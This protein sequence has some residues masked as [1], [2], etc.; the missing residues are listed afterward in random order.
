[1]FV[2]DRTA[3]KSKSKKPD[4]V[5][6]IPEAD[7]T[8]APARTLRKRTS[9]K[10]VKAQVLVPLLDVLIQECSLSLR[11]PDNLV[12]KP[13]PKTRKRA[14][15]TV[16]TAEAK[17]AA[18]KK[19]RVTARSK[20]KAKQTEED[21]V[22]VTAAEEPVAGPST[23]EEQLPIAAPEAPAVPEASILEPEL[24][25]D[26][27]YPEPIL[28]Q[29]ETDVSSADR[30]PTPDQV[31]V[32]GSSTSTP[33]ASGSTTWT[34]KPLS[35][36]D[37]LNASISALYEE[38]GSFAPDAVAVSDTA[39]EYKSLFG[40][41]HRARAAL[42]YLRPNMYAA[43]HAAAFHWEKLRPEVEAA[44]NEANG[45]LP[46][47]QAIGKEAQPGEAFVAIEWDW[48][49][50]EDRKDFY[51]L[52][53]CIGQL[54]GIEGADRDL[55]LARKQLA[56]LLAR[57]KR[58]RDQMIA[59]GKIVINGGDDDAFMLDIDENDEETWAAISAVFQQASSE[60][61][62]DDDEEDPDTARDN[63]LCANR[64]EE[65]A[66]ADD[67]DSDSDDEYVDNG[68]PESSG[69]SDA[70]VS[71]SES[72]DD[73]SGSSSDTE[74]AGSPSR[75]PSPIPHPAPAPGP[76]RRP[77]QREF[78]VADL[79]RPEPP[80]PAPR[81]LKREYATFINERTGRAI[82]T[83]REIEL[84][85]RAAGEEPE[86]LMIGPAAY[87]QY[88][89]FNAEQDQRD[90]EPSQPAPRRRKASHRPQK[91]RAEAAQN[92]AEGSSN[93]SGEESELA[94]YTSPEN[95]ASSSTTPAAPAP[96]VPAVRNIPPNRRLRR[97]S[98]FLA[99]DAFTTIRPDIPA[100]APAPRPASPASPA[101]ST[102]STEPATSPRGS[103]SPP[104]RGPPPYVVSDIGRSVLHELAAIDEAHR[105]AGE[106]P[107]IVFAKRIKL[108]HIPLPEPPKEVARPKA[109]GQPLKRTFAVYEDPEEKNDRKHICVWGASQLV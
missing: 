16:D 24:V 5:S 51:V 84:A 7:P 91:L 70:E 13:A 107:A 68:D 33:V 20:G 87:K 34:P 61:D 96:S 1:M 4:P 11:A 67:D 62:V 12:S 75:S 17:P 59:S 28:T 92:K 10:E 106:G 97:E 57:R 69:A 46:K 39:P 78:A 74:A 38:G 88:K 66:D 21:V 79:S 37:D 73:G 48:L 100:R 108:D 65:P 60:L 22:I 103:P 3:Q 56:R 109:K 15:S 30:E 101:S 42:N 45:D 29:V 54:A 76:S 8:P 36:F 14:L 53:A 50:D 63:A 105:A 52:L 64:T 9:T 85:A 25:Q 71:D 58:R 94:Q 77:L 27:A 19:P 55:N 6:V 18:A 41:Y 32:A 47:G 43:Q 90:S 44:F 81:P 89:K 49:T 40:H 31:L 104:S 93:S 80:R 102:S 86:K 23:A 72:S 83:P 26:A 2:G 35:D 95:G 99:D 98:T 82:P